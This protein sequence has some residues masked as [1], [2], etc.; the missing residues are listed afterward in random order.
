MLMDAMRDQRGFTLIEL[1][2]SLFIG[3]IVILASFMVLDATGPLAKKA[4]DRVDAAQRGRQ[5]MEIV[6]SELRSQVCLPGGAS[7]PIAP[8]VA[9]ANG[10]DLTFYSNLGDETNPPQRRRLFVQGDALIEQMW[11]GTYSGSGTTLTVNWPGTITNQRTLLQPIAQVGTTPYFGYWGFDANLPATINTPLNTLPLSATDAAKVVQ[12]DVSFA[13]RP[14]N[15]KT[16]SDI[17]SVY[18]QSIFFRTADPMDPGKGPKC[19]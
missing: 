19:Q 9:G 8:V 13:S 11:Q 15:A 4:Q 5:A 12:V 16:A 17:D 18:Q 10:S 7:G 6:G 3:T 14:S 2:I 1:V